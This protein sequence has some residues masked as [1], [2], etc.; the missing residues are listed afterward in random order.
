VSGSGSIDGSIE[1]GVEGGGPERRR[2]QQAATGLGSDV[3][4]KHA[5]G[6]RAGPLNKISN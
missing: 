6:D 3:A 1:L 5:G 4:V 2:R